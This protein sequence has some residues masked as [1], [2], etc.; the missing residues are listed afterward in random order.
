MQDQPSF[1]VTR[2]RFIELA[3]VAAGTGGAV[4][5]WGLG[6]REASS[7]KDHGDLSV[8]PHGSAPVP[9]RLG[10]FPDRLHAFLWRNWTLIPLERLAETLGARAA[11]LRAL[12]R[13]M[14]LGRPPR[15]SAGQRRRSY[16][17][18]IK[19]NWHL[20]PYEQLLTLLG[21]SA[22]ELAYVLR[23]DDF[24]W[25]KLGSLKPKCEPLRWTAPDP[26]VREAAARVDRVVH[27]QFG[28]SLPDPHEAP[29]TFVTELCRR[30]VEEPRSRAAGSAG[31]RFCYSYF[32]LYGD[33]LLEPDLDPYPDGYLAQL[34]AAGVNGVW[35]QAVLYRLAPF[36]WQPSLSARHE[37]RLRNLASLVARARRRGIRVF[38]YLNE[39]RAMP[40]AFFK[41]H[42][43]LK[44]V[45]EG[46][47]AALCTSTVPVRKYLSDSIASI[48]RAVP[49]L[50]GFFTI[51]AS[52]NFTSCWSHGGGAMCPRC[53][54]K[55]AP[56]VISDVI[57]AFQKGIDDVARG[58]DLIAW[59]WG[60]AD[61]WAPELIS[62]LPAQVMLQS[63]SEWSL[64]IERGGVKSAVGEY[65]IS[66]VGPGPRASL[67]WELAKRRGLRTVAKI[68]ANNTWELSALPY[69]PV[70]A[71]VAEHA[72][73]LRQR[74][75]DGIML[76][77]TLGGYP[78]PN[79]ETI[80][81][82]MAGGSLDDVALRRFGAGLAP[83][84]LAGWAAASAAFCE[85]PFS[86]EVVYS[87]PLQNGPSN[88]L[89]PEGTGYR[90]SMVGF[91]YDDLEGWRGPYPAEV[92]IG[93]LEK[94]AA[95]FVAAAESLEVAL[96]RNHTG[97][98]R[99]RRAALAEARLLRA[100]SV[101]FQSVANQSRF[102]R[103]RD[104]LKAAKEAKERAGVLTELERVIR[105]ELR[106]ALEM[107]GLQSRDS[108][109]GFEASNQYYYLPIDLAEKV[110]NCDWLLEQWL[111][112]LRGA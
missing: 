77:W 5:A 20:L 82:V 13:S 65:S 40:L 14:G 76:G 21:W 72:G 57:A 43:E 78:S 59:D 69:L 75:L 105:D 49:D 99:D 90:C 34:A 39:P 112:R 8:L 96:K 25:V 46:D 35:L 80:A 47:H 73:H 91:P 53:G 41:D 7:R 44:G 98:S 97:S 23:E 50:G 24:L 93:Q 26:A 95:G 81:T 109:L 86:V 51:T 66:S 61:S 30:P 29:F 103:A 60:W 27:G 88:L 67:H 70:L 10:H 68:Q 100:G 111:P 94:V 106:L 64:P 4:P 15:I 62:K 104:A 87:A 32:A 83:L 31:L 9:L 84:V 92:F 37:E 101:H 102:V 63:V 110:L 89:W 85:F 45:T 28:G 3:A 52:E 71:N 16:I 74:S 12:G 108:R 48:C 18:I 6:S 42:P 55:S 1:S 79:L 54:L 38:L 2:R 17:T 58:Q 22:E 11:D 19:R 33:P 36:P 107:H 56:D